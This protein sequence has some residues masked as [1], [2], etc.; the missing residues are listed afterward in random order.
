MIFDS[1]SHTSFSTDSDMTAED[2]LK[3][4]RARG[5]GLVFTEHLREHPH[6]KFHCGDIIVEEYHFIEVWLFQFD[7]VVLFYSGR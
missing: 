5:I 6:H 4:A 1:H 2:A 7:G 3:A